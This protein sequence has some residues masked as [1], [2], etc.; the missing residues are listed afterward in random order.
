[1]NYK[2]IAELLDQIIDIRK[3]LTK[4]GDGYDAA[5]DQK[6]GSSKVADNINKIFT[7][8]DFLKDAEEELSSL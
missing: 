2:E 7:A 6:G 5:F 3:M 4:I 1:M 8:R